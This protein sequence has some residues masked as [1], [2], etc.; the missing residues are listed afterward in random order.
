MELHIIVCIKSVATKAPGTG[1]VRFADTADLN[2]FDRPALE[3]AISLVE[4]QGGT[5]TVL[6]MGP[7]SCAFIL[8]EAMAM[9]GDRGILLSDARLADSDNWQPQ[10]R[11]PPRSK[12]L[13]PST[14]YFSEHGRMTATR[15]RSDRR[16][17]SLSTRHW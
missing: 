6:S 2:P 10:R 8:H 11:S 5:V 12:N 1:I 7:P 15:D 4:V 16:P 9:G 14:W 3:V 17:L 13:L